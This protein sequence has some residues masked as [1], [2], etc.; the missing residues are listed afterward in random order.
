MIFTDS[1]IQTMVS[2]Y[3]KGNSAA[4]IC[5]VIKTTPHTI[6]SHLRKHGVQIRGKAGYKPLINDTYFDLIDTER[7]AYFLGYLMADGNV[8]KRERSQ[9]VIRMEL[10]IQDRFILEELKKDLNAYTK[11]LDT[12]K[13]CCSLRIHSQKLFD[14]L[15]QYGI[16]PNRV[17]SFP[18]EQIPEKLTNHFLRGF[19]DGDGWMSIN[20]HGNRKPTLHVGF[21]GNP[22]IMK[23]IRDFFEIKLGTYHLK[24]TPIGAKSNLCNLIYS[25]K[26]DVYEICKYLYKNATLY[27]SRKRDKYEDFFHANTEIA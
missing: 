17:K 12:R 4:D 7:K 25:S 2:L 18:Q 19:F 26:R 3:E 11:V 13:N 21:C 23:D 10:S 14:S 8:M 16:V 20:S 9:P 5:K 6:I 27:L 15:G 24:V 1:E 22:I